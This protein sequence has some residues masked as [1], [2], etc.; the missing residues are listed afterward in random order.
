MSLKKSLDS[1]EKARD[2]LVDLLNSPDMAFRL[3][4]ARLLLNHAGLFHRLDDSSIED[5]V[6]EELHEFLAWLKDEEYMPSGPHDPAA[7]VRAYWDR[8]DDDE[9]P[10]DAES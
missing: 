2:S 10:T 7:L 1:T 4:A 6:N 3:E 5:I 9:E 8:P